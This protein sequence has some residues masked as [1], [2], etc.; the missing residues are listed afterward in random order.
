MGVV[1]D[2]MQDYPAIV[3]YFDRQGVQ[4]EIDGQHPTGEDCIFHKKSGAWLGYASM[5]CNTHECMEC[6]TCES[7]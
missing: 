1:D 3:K 4:I 6:E 7:Y 5:F 2:A